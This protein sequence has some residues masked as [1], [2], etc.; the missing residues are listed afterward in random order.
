M[1][2]YVEGL[3]E[4]VPCRKTTA[5]SSSCQKPKS[6]KSPPYPSSRYKRDPSSIRPLNEDKMEE[7]LQTILRAIRFAHRDSRRIKFSLTLQ[8]LQKI[9]TVMPPTFNIELARSFIKDLLPGE[10]YTQ[11]YVKRLIT[12]Y[13][14]VRGISEKQ[15]QLLQIANWFN[16]MSK[17]RKKKNGLIFC[18]VYY[19]C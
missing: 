3:P 8:I 10:H 14:L 4:P 17:W 12:A 7:L 19:V 18:N 5:K 13:A 15:R 2:S 1:S 11:K 9:K 6:S 16:I